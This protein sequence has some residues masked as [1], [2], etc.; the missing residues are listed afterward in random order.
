MAVKSSVLALLYSLFLISGK[1]FSNIT[2]LSDD[3]LLRLKSSWLS[4]QKRRTS[5]PNK[6]EKKCFSSHDT[7]IDVSYIKQMIESQLLK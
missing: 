4:I 2:F 5:L 6:L 3:F 7:S 1:I